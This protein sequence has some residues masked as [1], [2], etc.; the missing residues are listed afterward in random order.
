[1]REKQ[2]EKYT[3]KK[4]TDN[5]GSERKYS[6]S[7]A[8]DMSGAYLFETAED[9][10][11]AKPRIEKA[12]YGVMEEADIATPAF[13][14]LARFEEP[15]NSQQGG[16]NMKNGSKHS[17]QISF[18]VTGAL[19]FNTADDLFLAKER[20]EKTLLGVM[21]STKVDSLSFMDLARLE[22]PTEALCPVDESGQQ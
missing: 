8:A 7:V 20:L 22:E 17:C 11:L 18:I 16:A 21:S 1:M 12:L 5:A 4:A 6:C 13:M 10:R 2:E 14:N 15:A 3:V 9:L 19:L